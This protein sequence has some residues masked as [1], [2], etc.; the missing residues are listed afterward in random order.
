M[1]CEV[2][3]IEVV[4]AVVVVVEEGSE[5][6]EGWI[7]SDSTGVGA[8]LVRN[9]LLGAGGVAEVDAPVGVGGLPGDAPFLLLPPEN[10]KRHQTQ[11]RT[12]GHTVKHK[13]Y[14]I[15]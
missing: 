14:N 13:D 6:V 2:S 4:A 11:K 12:H 7:T 9:A 10:N 5:G 3:V 1:H 15:I 8:V